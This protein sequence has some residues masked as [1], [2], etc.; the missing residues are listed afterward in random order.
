[1]VRWWGSKAARASCRGL[2][3]TSG[4]EELGQWRG[5]GRWRH[6][7][8]SATA[9]SSGGR[10]GGRDAAT[11]KTRDGRRLAVGVE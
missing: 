5:W 9:W 2:L 8:S 11:K 4:Q 3:W 7:V 1:V 10:L 6:P